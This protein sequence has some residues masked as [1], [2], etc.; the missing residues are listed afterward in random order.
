MAAKKSQ[1]PA[2]AQGKSIEEIA[3]EAAAL[4]DANII[5]KA[6]AGKALSQKQRS[7]L[8]ELA[9]QPDVGVAKAK[10]II[11]L[12]EALG[13]SRP[14]I[15]KYKDLPGAPRA[16]GE[17]RYDIAEWKGFIAS[18]GGR[19][20]TEGVDIMGAIK[21]RT[22]QK[23]EQLLDIELGKAAGTLIPRAV[24]MPLVKQILETC[25]KWANDQPKKVRDSY[26]AYLKNIDLDEL[27]KTVFKS[28]D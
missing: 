17:G 13:L 28:R 3:R 20:A 23:E 10:S 19:V 12:A 7:R 25:K 27:T 15:Y 2:E 6:K 4:D 11:K 5:A 24:V 8:Q 18:A 22:A 14:T 26:N 9:G 1:A 21:T 16:D